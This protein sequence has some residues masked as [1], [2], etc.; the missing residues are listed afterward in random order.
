MQETGHAGSALHR[1]IEQFSLGGGRGG[2]LIGDQTAI[3]LT[4]TRT[5]VHTEQQGK[6]HGSTLG[7][8]LIATLHKESFSEVNSF[9]ISFPLVFSTEREGER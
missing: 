3:P 6:T 5:H 9:Q 4:V 2:Q 1:R 7:R 8:Q